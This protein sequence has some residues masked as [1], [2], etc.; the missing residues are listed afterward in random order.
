MVLAG[1]LKLHF[2]S[3]YF[4]KFL[5]NTNGS[6]GTTNNVPFA[7]GDLSTQE[8]SIFTVEKASL[9]QCSHGH[10]TCHSMT[11]LLGGRVFYNNYCIKKKRK[12]LCIL[13]EGAQNFSILMKSHGCGRNLKQKMA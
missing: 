12:A 5:L 4:S 2:S 3:A 10:Y 11:M 8:K 13:W 1:S 6:G 9:C 7:D